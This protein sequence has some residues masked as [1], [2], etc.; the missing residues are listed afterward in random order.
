MSADED[1]DEDL[2]GRAVGGVGDGW[3]GV[4]ELVELGRD[5]LDR[6]GFLQLAGLGAAAASLAACSSRPSR[7]I[8]PYANQPPELSPGVA[9]HYATALVEDGFATGVLVAA[10]EGRPVKVEGNPDHPASLGA[11]RAIEQAAVLSLFD[12]ERLQ[13]IHA[14]GTPAPWSAVARIL[15]DAAAARGAG[16]HLVLEPTTSPLVVALVERVRARLPAAG[17]TFW[18]PFAPRAALEGHRLAF[19]RPLQAQLDLRAADVIVALDAD[20]VAGHPMA[21]AYARQISDRR[22]VV[23]GRSAMSRLYALEAHHS[24]TGVI[25][26]HRIAVRGSQIEPIA[27]ELL[28]AVIRARRGAAVPHGRYALAERPPSY[29]WLSAVAGDLVAAAGRS[30]VVAGERQPAIVHAAVAAINA[31]LGNLG[32]TVQLVEPVAFE[33]GEASHSLA[34]LAHALERGGVT[35][36]VVLGGNPAYSAPAEARLAAAIPRV[37]SSV[38]VG[39]YDNETARACKLAVPGL[40]D[41]ERWDLARAYDGTLTPIQPLIEPLFAGRSVADVLHHLLGDPVATDHDRVRAAWPALAAGASFEQALA[42]GKLAG[43]AAP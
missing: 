14:Q 42:L 5:Q 40:H 28:A 37:A 41:L 25:A 1:L 2:V 20:L 7:E 23:D 11:T 38:Y 9:Q 32:R 4:R 12:P 18:S 8:L 3:A 26:D 15:D 16:L 35:S 30:V 39:L 24:P 21:L 31:V 22:R 17:I 13:A 10:H 6:R 27:L 34:E 43:T 36:L 29:E 33:A 19:G